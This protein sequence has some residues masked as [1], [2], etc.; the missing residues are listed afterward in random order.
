MPSRGG[1]PVR[2]QAARTRNSLMQPLTRAPFA[3]RPCQKIA[4]ERFSAPVVSCVQKNR[5]RYTHAAC[6]AE[7]RQGLARATGHAI[8]QPL[9]SRNKNQ[10]QDARLPHTEIGRLEC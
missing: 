5:V 6:A 7:D 2:Q 3:T 8:D 4:T 9:P 10:R 1:R